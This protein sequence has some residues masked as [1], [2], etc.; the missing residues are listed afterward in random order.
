MC[1]THAWIQKVLSEGSN[2]DA[3]KVF[4]S[5]VD[6]G[7]EDPNTSKYGHHRPASDK[8]SGPP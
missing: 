4:F 7:R 6:E 5:L 8:G 2:P 3:D 1:F